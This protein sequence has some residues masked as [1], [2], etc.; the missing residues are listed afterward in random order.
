ME[1]SFETTYDQ[2][3]LTAM[4]KGLRKTVRKKRSRRSHILGWIIIFLATFLG[5]FSGPFDFRAAITLLAALVMFVVL[6]FED[7]INGYF[8][9]KRILPGTETS[10]SYFTADVFSSATKI[11]KSE[12]YY[13]NIAALAEAN[14][15]FIFLFSNNHAQVYDKRTLTGGCI[16]EFRGFIQDKTQKTIVAV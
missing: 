3:A 13:E 11:G 7:H 12:F 9:G 8:A 6:C 16:D 14:H 15:Y 2:K 10:I 4:A 1:F 5:L